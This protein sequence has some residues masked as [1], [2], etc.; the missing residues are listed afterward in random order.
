MT[1]PSPMTQWRVMVSPFCNFI[2]VPSALRHVYTHLPCFL[3]CWG[4]PHCPFG[5]HTTW[6]R[7]FAMSSPSTTPASSL[8]CCVSTC[9]VHG[10]QFLVY[11]TAPLVP[12]CPHLQD[13]GGS[14]GPK[15]RWNIQTHQH[16]YPVPIFLTLVYYAQLRVQCTHYTVLDGLHHSTCTST[17]APILPALCAITRNCALAYLRGPGGTCVSLCHCFTWSHP[18]TTEGSLPSLCNGCVCATGAV[19]A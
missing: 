5:S 11:S 16:H 17:P 19:C 10:W 4:S 2:P 18:F 6:H 9:L 15:W 3:V 8:S 1:P 7:G 13:K 12:F 14:K